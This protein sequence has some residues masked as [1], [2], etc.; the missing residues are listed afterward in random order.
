MSVRIPVVAV[1]AD[2]PVVE[3]PEDLGMIRRS[4]G[5]LDGDDDGYTPTEG[6]NLH[7]CYTELRTARGK[8]SRWGKL[9]NVEAG[10]TE[11]GNA[12]L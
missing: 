4:C 9:A 1:L 5:I 3:H 8:R 7:S 2:D 6:S 12:H 10:T 11:S